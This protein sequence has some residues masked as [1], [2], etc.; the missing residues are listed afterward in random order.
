MLMQKFKNKSNLNKSR[1]LGISKSNLDFS[2][3]KLLILKKLFGNEA[4][5]YLF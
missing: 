4:N 3:I 2:I 5:T 1:T